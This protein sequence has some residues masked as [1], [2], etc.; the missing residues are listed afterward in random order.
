MRGEFSLYDSLFTGGAGLPYC[1]VRDTT[2]T[3]AN[4]VSTTVFRDEVIEYIGLMPDPLARPGEYS[5]SDFFLDL[6]ETG[7]NHYIYDIRGKKFLGAN[8]RIPL[9]MSPGK[10]ELFALVPY[11]IK[12]LEL[13]LKTPVVRTGNTID[14]TVTIIPRDLNAVPGRH[15][16]HVEVL[17]V[18]GSVMPYF[19]G[20]HEAVKGVLNSSIT[21]GP[22]D[23][24]GRC[25]LQVTDVITGKKAERAFMVMAIGSSII[26]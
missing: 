25:S 9:D 7:K 10:A 11:R 5:G 24:P 23:T 21:I 22:D 1:S 17:G 16:F 3:V 15:V 18:D 4:K 2:G 8:T 13:K 6:T 12:E 20:N 26:D 14:Y 19:T